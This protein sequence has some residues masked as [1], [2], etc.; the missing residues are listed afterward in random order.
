MFSKCELSWREETIGSSV[1]AELARL[2]WNENGT[3]T[4]LPTCGSVPAPPPLTPGPQ[5]IRLST[6][7]AGWE[8]QMEH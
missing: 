3:L 7:E 5:D 8:E 1:T 4:P 2:C 6:K